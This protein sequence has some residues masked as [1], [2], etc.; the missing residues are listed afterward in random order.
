MQILFVQKFSATPLFINFIDVLFQNGAIKFN[1]CIISKWCSF[2]NIY[3]ILKW[4]NFLNNC[5]FS[6][7][8]RFF[9][10]VLFINSA[11]F[12]IFALFL[13]FFIKFIIF[14]KKKKAWEKVADQS[15][16]AG[17]IGPVGLAWADC[18]S[19]PAD[20]QGNGP[21]GL[22]LADWAQSTQA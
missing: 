15:A 1:I 21:V 8:C 18:M 20:I 19:P 9:I 10:I 5:N 4:C 22:G 3:I 12:I 17:P 16:Q 13:Q 6:K 2:F 14:S 7:W 11:I